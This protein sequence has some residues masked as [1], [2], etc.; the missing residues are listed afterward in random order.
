MI[1]AMSDAGPAICAASPG[2]TRMPDPRTELTYNATAWRSVMAL[3]SDLV[4]TD[5]V[6]DMTFSL[7]TDGMNLMINCRGLDA[8]VRPDKNKKDCQSTGFSWECSL[9]KM[10]RLRRQPPTIFRNLR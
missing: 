1:Q 10:G 2:R 3:V 7:L 9:T 5:I 8:S 6:D 4:C